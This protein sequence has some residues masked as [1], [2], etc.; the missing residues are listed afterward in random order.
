MES[1]V[2]SCRLKNGKT[3]HLWFIKNIYINFLVMIYFLYYRMNMFRRDKG[4]TVPVVPSRSTQE[5]RKLDS[6][7]V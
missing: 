5:V 1:G 3:T 2:H 6:G 7:L 4:S